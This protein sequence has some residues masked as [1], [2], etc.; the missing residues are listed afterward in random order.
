MKRTFIALALS[1]EIKTY[2]SEIQAYI[3]SGTSSIKLVRPENMHV[4]L[5]FLGEK[6]NQEIDIICDCLEDIPFNITEIELSHVDFFYK[7]RSNVCYVALKESMALH[8]LYQ[9]IIA[10]LKQEGIT[11]QKQPYKAHIPIAREVRLKENQSFVMPYIKQKKI[12][13]DSCCLYHSHR[14]NNQLVYDPLCCINGK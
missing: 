14:R 3:K 10:S 1:S 6:T 11:Y 5:V 12:Q 7:K 4:T 8:Q 2:L 9:D 13:M